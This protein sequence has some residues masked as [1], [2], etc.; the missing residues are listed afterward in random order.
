MSR[1]GH[2]STTPTTKSKPTRR[3]PARPASLKRHG[4]TWGRRRAVVDTAGDHADPGH[5]SRATACPLPRSTTI[6]VGCSGRSRHG[7]R[8]PDRTPEAGHWTPGR[9]DTRPH[10]TPDTDQ[11]DSH[12]W[13]TGRSHR[14]P[15]RTGR[16]QHSPGVG[17]PGSPRRATACWNAQPCF[18]SRTTRQPLGRSVGRA[19]PR[20]TAV[21]GRFRVESRSRGEA[22]SVMTVRIGGCRLGSWSNPRY[23]WPWCL[24]LDLSTTGPG[25]YVLPPDRQVC[26]DRGLAANKAPSQ[27]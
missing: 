15:T 23:D 4:P 1:C 21:L 7:H 22:S 11:L 2:C 3:C 19:A 9:S 16:R 12:P 5:P 14:T 25:R 18:C 6:P 26:P 20:R 8:T 24:V 27:S 17:P 10:R 13:D